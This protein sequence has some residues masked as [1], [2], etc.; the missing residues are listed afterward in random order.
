MSPKVT[1]PASVVKLVNEIIVCSSPQL[2]LYGRKGKTWAGR[3]FKVQDYTVEGDGSMQGTALGRMPHPYNMEALLSFLNSNPYHST[4]IQAKVAATVGLGFKLDSQKNKSEASPSAP[5]TQQITP[6]EKSS[7]T[8]RLLSKA[9]EVLNPLC[10]VSLSDLLDSVCE[11][12]WQTGNGYIEVKR[13]GEEILGLYRI[14]PKNIYVNIENEEGDYHFDFEGTTSKKFC[15]FGDKATFLARNPG[16]TSDPDSISEVIHLPQATSQHTHYGWARWLSAVPLIELAQMLTQHKFDFFQNRG[17]PEFM[18]FILGQKLS[19]EEWKKV[20]DSLRA[21]IGVGNSHK[22]FAL[23]LSNPEIKIQL[24]KLVVDSKGEET[25]AVL[26]EPVALGIVTAHQ[27]P[28][29]LAGILIP[30]KLGA[31]NELPNAMAAFQALVIGRA[32]RSFQQI[33]G[34]TLGGEASN[35]PLDITDFEF[36]SIL[37]EIDIGSMD[38]IARMREPL[39]KAQ[40]SGR[41]LSAGVKS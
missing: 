6:P 23:N 21:N 16:L 9:D 29:L 20:E 19:E 26:S 3:I 22:T 17:V 39:P 7:S 31:T 41:D 35:L 5:G 40:A 15:R 28:P 18:L 4:C 33:L 14:S 1:A 2:D 13:K 32:Q 36:Y 12:Y 24:E 37:D 30:G 27:V 34:S 38:T 8:D 10:Q 25:Y 11:D